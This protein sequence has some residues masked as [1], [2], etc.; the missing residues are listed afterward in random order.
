MSKLDRAFRRLADRVLVL[1]KF[2]RMGVK[3]HICLSEL[4]EAERESA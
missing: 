3:L 2:K 4:R 1:E